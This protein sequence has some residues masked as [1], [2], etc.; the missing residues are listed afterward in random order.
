M[1]KLYVIVIYL[2]V[3]SFI[4]GFEAVNMAAS[5]TTDLLTHGVEITVQDNISNSTFS[6]SLGIA[7]EDNETEHGTLA[8]QK[9]DLEGMFWNSTNSE[10]SVIG[11]FNYVKGAGNVSIGDVFVGDS[12]VFD[13]ERNHKDNLLWGGTFDIIQDYTSWLD[14]TYVAEST[15]F[16]YDGGGTII[17]SGTY[18]I[19]GFYGDS[20]DPIVGVA[21]W[22][23]NDMHWD[24]TLGGDG[25][26]DDILTDGDTIHLTMGCGNDTIHG[27]VGAN[28]VPIPGTCALLLCPLVAM[29]VGKR[30]LNFE[31]F[32]G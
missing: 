8:V 30:R 2:F 13:F 26:F 11:G 23:G 7:G 4:M 14:P 15:P 21:G 18:T 27:A 24:L 32:E 3:W 20:Q 16:Q 9:F 25:I 17:G 1:K 19:D 12:F 29:I 5:Q 10:L 22:R 31:S 6:E 28:A